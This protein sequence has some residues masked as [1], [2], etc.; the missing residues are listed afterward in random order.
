M[1]Q[2]FAVIIITL[3]AV[4]FSGYGDEKSAE[5][6]QVKCDKNDAK[7]CVILG[8]MY[9]RGVVGDYDYKKAAKL[10]EKAC[11]LNE[12]NACDRLANFYLFKIGVEH[13]NKEQIIALAQKAYDHGELSAGGILSNY[14]F[15]DSEKS[16][17]FAKKSCDANS[18]LGCF[19]LGYN[20]NI[21]SETS[22]SDSNIAETFYAKSAKL[23]LKKCEDGYGYENCF[24]LAH[25]YRK[26]IGVER[27]HTK[28]A[29]FFKKACKA[30][31]VQACNELDE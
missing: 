26:A 28:A 22:N 27:N 18:A 10:Y 17:D 6:F 5:S 11:D 31:R 25:Y 30:K 14:Y 19:L 15:N 9:E 21:L 8:D 1:K 13:R 20:Y 7:S 29:T 16:I 12:Y 23:Y 3:L 2:L 4:V 24:A